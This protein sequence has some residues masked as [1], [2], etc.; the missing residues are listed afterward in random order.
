MKPK[1]DLYSNDDTC[2]KVYDPNQKKVIGVYTTFRKAAD[3]MG[4]GEKLLKSRAE[5][6]I[7]VYSEYYG[8]DVAIRHSRLKEGDNILIEK[9]L[10]NKKL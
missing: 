4:L 10:K 2:V 5:S 3:K 7:R 8:M 1:L 6:K 9:T